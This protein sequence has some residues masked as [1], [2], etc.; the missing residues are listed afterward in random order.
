MGSDFVCCSTVVA[1]VRHWLKYIRTIYCSEEEQERHAFPPSMQNLLGWSNCF[2]CLGTFTNYLGYLRSACH[3]QGCDA[4]PVGHPALR[5]A[6]ISIVKRELYQAKPKMFINKSLVS[7]MVLSVQRGWEDINGAALWLTS[8]IFL[9]RLPSEAL[10]ACRGSPDNSAL[11]DKQTLIW[12]DGNEICL[13]LL[14]RKNRDHGSGILRRGCTCNL[15]I[16]KT[17]PAAYSTEVIESSIVRQSTHMCPVHGLWENFWAGRAEGEQPWYHTIDA[18]GARLR[19]REL[20][21]KLKVPAAQRY[22]THDFRR[23][24]AEDMRKSG[25]T[26]AEI[27]KAGQWRSAAFMSYLDEAA[28]DKASQSTSTCIMTSHRRYLSGY[29]VRSRHAQRRGVHRLASL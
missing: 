4:P 7:D 5:L 18:A 6:M 11:A 1:G 8:Y 23:G 9:L 21:Q 14:R 2:Q 22:G 13:R 12:K 10:P 19:M 28:M 24:H 26:L 25:C 17:R 3:A 20:L 16:R 15:R 29:G 27:L